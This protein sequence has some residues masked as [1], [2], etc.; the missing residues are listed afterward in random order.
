MVPINFAISFPI[1]KNCES[2]TFTNL[3]DP[4]QILVTAAGISV[5][6][7][8]SFEFHFLRTSV[9]WSGTYRLRSLFCLLVLPQQ[10]SVDGTVVVW[11]RNSFGINDPLAVGYRSSCTT[12]QCR[13]MRNQ[14]NVGFV[15]VFVTRLVVAITERGSN[16]LVWTLWP[17]IVNGVINDSLIACTGLSW[18]T[19]KVVKQI[20]WLS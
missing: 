8:I 11:V 18:N 10:S 13:R 19:E 5:N 3:A 4:T 20:G 9:N 12:S 2:Q 17:P 1:S 16:F 6:T 15:Q 7:R 14:G